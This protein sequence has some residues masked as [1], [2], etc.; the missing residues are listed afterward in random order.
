LY[1]SSS[2]SVT[3]MGEHAS[4][5]HCSSPQPRG[6]A[7]APRRGSCIGVQPHRMGGLLGERARLGEENHV[8]GG[9]AHILYDE[10]KSTATSASGAFGSANRGRGFYRRCMETSARGGGTDGNEGG[11]AKRG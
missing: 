8:L 7:A 11:E 4:Q 3:A 5:R 1:A 2:L 10:D 6:R 9:G